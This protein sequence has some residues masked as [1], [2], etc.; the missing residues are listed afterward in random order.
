M[1]QEDSR[2]R[3]LGPKMAVC[4]PSCDTVR[5]WAEEKRSQRDS[6]HL[7]GEKSQLPE[8]A[9]GSTQRSLP[10]RPTVHRRAIRS[11]LQTHQ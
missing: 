1:A 7:P 3:S 9:S 11:L 5:L 10:A 4:A 8:P 6:R 2:A